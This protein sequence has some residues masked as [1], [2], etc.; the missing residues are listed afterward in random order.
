MTLVLYVERNFNPAGQARFGIQHLT[1]AVASCRTANFH[2]DVDAAASNISWILNHVQDDEAL[3]I[4]NL[5]IW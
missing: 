3:N 4:D 2:D 5:P 1:D